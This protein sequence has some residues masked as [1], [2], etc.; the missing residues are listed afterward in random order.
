M[1]AIRQQV[2]GFEPATICL[3]GRGPTN[4][5]TPANA[6]P[7]IRTSNR[8]LRRLLHSPIVLVGRSR[9]WDLNPRGQTGGLTCYQTTSTLRCPRRE[10][11]THLRLRRTSGLVLLAYE[12]DGRERDR[13]FTFAFSGRRADHYATRP[14]LPAG[15]EPASVD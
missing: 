2:A 7:R 11:N 6:P 5:A 3:E 10:S 1:F 8:Q 12:D 13:T 15:F 9:V 4:W 14:I